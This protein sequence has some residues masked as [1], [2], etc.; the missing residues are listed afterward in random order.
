MKLPVSQSYILTKEESDELITA[1]HEMEA[2]EQRANELRTAFYDCWT[3]HAPAAPG[4]AGLDF[5]RRITLS[6]S[7]EIIVTTTHGQ[8]EI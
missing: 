4:E 2:A 5:D 6:A 7:G 8:T 1:A 3:K